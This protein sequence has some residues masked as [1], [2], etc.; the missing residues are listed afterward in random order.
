M[1][2][3]QLNPTLPLD[4]PKG[5]GY[6][7]FILDMGQEHST[8]FL[9]FLDESREPWWFRQEQVRLQKNYTMSASEFLNL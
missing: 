2:L 1:S 4:T 5:K 3:L 9:V 7:H 6:A 8:L